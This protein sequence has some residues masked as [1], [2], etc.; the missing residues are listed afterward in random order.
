MSEAAKIAVWRLGQA[1]ER[2]RGFDA[3]RVIPTIPEGREVV[4]V[5]DRFGV[6]VTDDDAVTI[7]HAVAER[8]G[9]RVDVVHPAAA[10]AQGWPAGVQ[11]RV[12]TEHNG[13][14]FCEALTRLRGPKDAGSTATVRLVATAPRR[15]A[16]NRLVGKNGPIARLGNV[17]ATV[18]RRAHKAIVSPRELNR[19]ATSAHPAGPKLAHAIRAVIGGTTSGEERVWAARIEALRA[20][21]LA[22]AEELEVVD[23]GAVEPGM[24][25]NANDMYEGRRLRRGVGEICRLTSKPPHWAL[26]LLELVR[27]FRPECC[28]EFG[29]SLGIS[30]SYEAAGLELNGTGN[31]VT[32]EGAGA[33]AARAGANLERLRL[34]ERVEIVVGRFQDTLGTVLERIGPVDYAFV[35]GHHDRDATLAYFEELAPSLA[36]EALLVFDD[37]SWSDGMADAWNRI[38]SD[39]RVSL[40]VDLFEVGVCVVGG[41]EVSRRR[42][43]V[44]ID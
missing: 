35:D 10:R 8:V 36:P 31:L 39:Q 13:G 26:L 25:I 24:E 20:E 27:T 22:S 3:G 29:T 42:F 11:E 15:A 14:T 1:K 5:G 2:E 32:L 4:R 23:Y 33:V 17:H 7:Q 40:S 44:A 30:T 18:R 43:T 28:V 16:G 34:A 21:L 12:S 19:L 38:R 37:V 6:V 9:S 41:P